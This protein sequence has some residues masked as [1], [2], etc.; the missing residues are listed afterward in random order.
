MLDQQRETYDTYEYF[1]DELD[2]IKV[3][4]FS[5]SMHREE[6]GFVRVLVK[7]GGDQ[8]LGATIIGQ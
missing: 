8:I 7:R 1:F 3:G 4:K 6:Y 2:R 5:E